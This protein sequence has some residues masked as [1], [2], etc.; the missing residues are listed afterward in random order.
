MLLQIAKFCSFYGQIIFHFVCVCVCVCVYMFKMLLNQLCL[1][2][3]SPMDYSLPGSSVHGILQ[4]RILEWVAVPFSRGSFWPRDWTRGS[5]IAHSHFPFVCLVPESGSFVYQEL[6]LDRDSK[7]ICTP[8]FIALFTIVKIWKQSKHPSTDEWIKIPTL[9]IT[10][11]HKERSRCV[12]HN[13]PYSTRT[14]A[15][16]WLTISC[17]MTRNFD[18]W[19]ISKER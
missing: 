6:A 2:P 3:C 7:N 1:T 12:I 9:K 17:V 14:Y 15:L 16:V 19:L 8:I 10:A 11:F 18:L 4:A 5:C 13:Y